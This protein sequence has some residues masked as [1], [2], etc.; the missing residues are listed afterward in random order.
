MRVDDVA[1]NICQGLPVTA[2]AAGFS[3]RLLHH[4]RL[5][6]SQH[7]EPASCYSPRHVKLFQPPF[8]ELNGIL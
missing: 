8:I 1:G 2:A 7:L 3:H 5:G 4:G 6:G